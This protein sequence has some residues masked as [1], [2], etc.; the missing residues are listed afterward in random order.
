MWKPLQLQ[1][2]PKMFDRRTEIPNDVE[3]LIPA[4]TVDDDGS[5][6]VGLLDLDE[7]ADLCEGDA[8]LQPC[9][10]LPTT[11]PTQMFVLT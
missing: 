7:A 4:D 2:H 10:S 8:A 9:L 5:A 11:R 1:L 3:A 6:N